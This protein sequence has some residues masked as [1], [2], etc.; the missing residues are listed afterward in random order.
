VGDM[1]RPKKEGMDYFPHDTDA[2]NDEKIEALRLLYGNDGYA[3]YF[4][5]LERIYRTKEFEL[6]VS[7]A[8]TIQ[9][10]SRKVGINE[11]KFLQIL[12][13]SLRRGC[14]D[15]QSY[16]ERKVLTSEGI[17]KRASVVV[18]KRVKMRDKYQQDK[19]LV[20]DAETTQE[21]EEETPQSKE[22]KSKEKNN[23]HK[24]VY[25]ETSIYYQLA[26]MLYE[27]I[28]KNMPDKKKPNLSQWADDFRK[29]VE[30]DGKDPK[31]I[32][33][34]IHWTQGNEF[35]WKN[36]LSASK[37]RS[38]YERLAAEVRADM[39]KHKKVTQLE[40]KQPKRNDEHIEKMKKLLGG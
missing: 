12:E 10:L 9:I 39:L 38:Q 26:S 19:E 23:S 1:A 16:E 35:W 17:K 8:E 34:V 36:V 29:L 40:P 20:S 6:D 33:T 24:Q 13:T 14:F 32:E 18:E 3:F 21:T 7:D 2:V 11:E 30:L 5:L 25:D 37:L 22:K 15:R 4:I 31:H 28:L 27:G